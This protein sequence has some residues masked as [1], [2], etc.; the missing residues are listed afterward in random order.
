L[1]ETRFGKAHTWSFIEK[2]FKKNNYRSN[3]KIGGEIG[4][5]RTT[6]I[7]LILALNVFKPLENGT[8]VF[9]NSNNI[10]NLYVNNQEY[11]AFKLKGIGKLPDNFGVTTRFNNIFFG[12]NLPKRAAFTFGAYHKF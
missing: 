10:T 5:K 4:R 8:I 6:H 12:N 2:N 11:G 7:C 1:A 9:L 3:F